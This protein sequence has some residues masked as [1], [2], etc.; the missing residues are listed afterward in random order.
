MSDTSQGPGWWLASDGKWYPPE[1]WTGG[2]G[3]A[4]P[5]TAVPTG[6]GA[7]VQPPMGGT[8]A[9]GYGGA[10]QVAIV[11]AYRKEADK[12]FEWLQKSFDARDSGLTQLLVTPFLIDF[13]DDP[14]FADICRKL[15]IPVAAP[16][17]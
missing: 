3:T 1:L 9:Y 8:P 4:P 17:K 10:F 2:P 16:G 14:R 5:G 13:R 7:P 6:K 11:Y 15:K 12:V